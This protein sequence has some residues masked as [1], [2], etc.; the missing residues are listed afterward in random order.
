MR[1]AVGVE[2]SGRDH[3]QR[4]GRNELFTGRGSLGGRRRIDF[5]GRQLE[6]RINHHIEDL[7]VLQ[8][9]DGE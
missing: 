2:G 8:G 1:V 9:G 4:D 6:I 7:G 5:V 3:L